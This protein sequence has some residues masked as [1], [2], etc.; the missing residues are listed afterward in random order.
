MIPN[1][2]PSPVLTQDF[3][4]AGGAPQIFGKKIYCTHWL[5]HGECD[6]IQQGCLYKHEMP[7]ELTLKSIGIRPY[8]RWY[9]ETHPEKFVGTDT[10]LGYIW[11]PTLANH[12][13]SNANANANAFETS[14]S[15]STIQTQYPFG[16]E[17]AKVATSMAAGTFASRYPHQPPIPWSAYNAAQQTTVHALP[18]G[19]G[20]NTRRA[21]PFPPHR[22]AYVH[23]V[24][25]A[26]GIPS[27][28]STVAPPSIPGSP[29]LGFAHVNIPKPSSAFNSDRRL[30]H[31]ASSSQT[32]PFH[33]LSP[34]NR[35]ESNSLSVLGTAPGRNGS[36]FSNASIAST[37]NRKYV[38]LAPE[39]APDVPPISLDTAVSASTQQRQ[40][41]GKEKKKSTSVSG[42]DRV[43]HK[44]LFIPKGA[45][46]FVENLDGGN[47]GTKPES[48]NG[49]SVVKKARVEDEEE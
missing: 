30:N 31:A 47:W 33:A 25:A 7:D 18:N 42:R 34:R 46:N 10:G 28:P 36:I 11:G 12:A 35:P 38:P 48:D 40:Q 2:M 19:K 3:T 21:G 1:R 5:R 37:V 39:R 22:T 9:M 32:S 23:Q 29:H 43:K 44:R 49:S 15:S 17:N 4:V 14:Q 24:T 8:P 26:R 20:H 13:Q 6:F 27:G 16:T 41:N 45:A